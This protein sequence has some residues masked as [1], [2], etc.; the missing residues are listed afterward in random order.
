MVWNY[1]KKRQ[2]NFAAWQPDRLKTI[3]KIMDGKSCLTRCSVHQTLP[4]LTTPCNRCW[5]GTRF[6]SVEGIKNWLDWFLDSNEE[7]FF[8]L[9]EILKLGEDPS[10]QWSTLLS[11]VF[12]RFVIYIIFVSLQNSNLYPDILR[13]LFPNGFVQL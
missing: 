12:V 4:L 5:T 7:R 10:F 3:W 8:F 11:N 6:T 2:S 1:R 13:D 9:Q